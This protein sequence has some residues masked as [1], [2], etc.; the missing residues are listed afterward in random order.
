MPQKFC[1][2]YCHANMQNNVRMK[3]AAIP[4][5]IVQDLKLR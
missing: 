4:K 3:I 1:K 5:T 2:I